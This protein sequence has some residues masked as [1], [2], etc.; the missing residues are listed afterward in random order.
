MR[1]TTDQLRELLLAPWH[2]IGVAVGDRV[3]VLSPDLFKPEYRTPRQI[4]LAYAFCRYRELAEEAIMTGA[5]GII[6]Q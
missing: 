1:W 2:R 6:T 5:G 3:R 4:Q